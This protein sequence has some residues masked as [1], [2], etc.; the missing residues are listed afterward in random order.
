MTQRKFLRHPGNKLIPNRGFRDRRNSRR[1]L[2]EERE[3]A[4]LKKTYPKEL[5]GKP[6]YMLTEISYPYASPRGKKEEDPKGY[7]TRVKNCKW[8]TCKLSLGHVG[9]HRLREKKRAST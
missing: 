9:R 5:E 1:E 3:S 4:E 8:R 2:L 6:D 7:P